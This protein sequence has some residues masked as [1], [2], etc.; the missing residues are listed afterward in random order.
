MKRLQYKIFFFSI[1]LLA[2]MGVT[3]PLPILPEIAKRFSLSA[4]TVGW[5]TVGYTMPGIIVA[6]IAG[7]LAD[8]FGRKIVLI[9]GL[10]LFCFGGIAC[11]FSKTFT[12]LVIYR[13]VQGIGGG[14]LGVLYATLPA[15][16]YGD[17]ELPSVMGQIS[18]VASFGIALFPAVGGLLGEIAWHLPFSISGLAL[19]V[20]WLALRLPFVGVN[21]K[22]SWSLYFQR[23]KKIITHKQAFV[24]FCLTF[25]CYC[26]Y[27]GPVNTYFPM[28]VHERFYVSSSDIGNVF[29]I[30]ALGISISAMNLGYLN[31][32]LSFRWL[33][34]LAGI[35]YFIAQSCFMLM[36]GILWMS[37]P[38][39]FEGFA[40]GITMPILTE[41]IA[42]LAP[43]DSR[44]AIMAVNGSIFRLS[45]SVAPILFGVSWTIL[46][47]F[48]PYVMGMFV[49]LFVVIVAVCCV[50][51]GS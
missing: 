36:P 50:Q 1:A 2:V 19:C 40:Q 17:A 38:L 12:V 33:I 23:I 51:K 37:I 46:G 44:A 41:R 5:V 26:I 45:Q 49:A 48:G 39:L 34:I 8:R 11:A 30:L 32:H 10:L 29:I 24:L 15:D 43:T 31:N 21:K 6:L 47:W 7:V 28:M 27:Y 13:A 20:V 3:I 35:G 4:E 42:I 22:I 14:V 16:V 18:A 9:V 25:L